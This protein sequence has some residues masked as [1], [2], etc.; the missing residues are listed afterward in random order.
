MTEDNFLELEKHWEAV[1]VTV[2]WHDER[3]LQWVDASNYTITCIDLHY[4]GNGDVV[5]NGER[6]L[7]IARVHANHFVPL[8]PI[9]IS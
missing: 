3:R 1:V 7:F 8:T 5:G 9:D 2:A 4:E 6:A